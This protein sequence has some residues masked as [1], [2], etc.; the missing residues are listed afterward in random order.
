MT[1]WAVCI[2]AVV[3]SILT[4]YL[5]ENQL[6]HNKSRFTVPTLTLCVVVIATLAVSAFKYPDAFS[7]SQQDLIKELSQLEELSQQSYNVTIEPN[8]IPNMSRGPKLLETTVAQ[9]RKAS[10]ESSRDWFDMPNWQ[11]YDTPDIEYQGIKVLNRD[12]SGNVPVVIVF[13]DSHANMLAQCF[14][15][16]FEDARRD[17]KPFPMVIFRTRD[18]SPPL[19][20]KYDTYPGDIGF[21]KSM[22]PKSVL[23]STNW[24]QFIRPGEK[25][26]DN[27]PNPKCCNYY[28][29]N[30]GEYQTWNDADLL[31]AKFRDDVKGLVADGT[32][33][34]VATI[35]PE[36]VEFDPSKMINGNAV[37]LATPVRRSTFRKKFEKL[38]GKIESAVTEAN[39]TLID[40]SDNQCWEDICEPVTMREGEPLMYDDDHF[41]PWIARNYL[42]VLDQVVNAAYE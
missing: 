29:D 12:D 13:G 6:R 40:Y 19:S 23:F 24:P 30:C 27:G 31:L 37:K 36:G 21:M 14:S 26:G 34:F 18:G 7:V 38:L 1:P 28:L 4:V 9:V 16:L 15:K 25:S 41:R 10:L 8:L 35:N 17:Q 39:A 11:G 5:V 20:C 22:K 32:K 33:V 3:L 2:A 42:S